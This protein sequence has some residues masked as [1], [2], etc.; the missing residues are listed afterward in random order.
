MGKRRHALPLRLDL[1]VFREV[2]TLTFRHQ[3]SMNLMLNEM[4]LFAS[5]SGTFQNFLCK[6]YPAPSDQGHFIYVRDGR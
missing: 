2:Q 3:I 6:Q 4:I 5:K 1:N